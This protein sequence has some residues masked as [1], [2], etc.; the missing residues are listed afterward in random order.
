MFLYR[1]S[2]FSSS[3]ALAIRPWMRL[4]ILPSIWQQKMATCQSSNFSQNENIYWTS[5]ITWGKL[6]FTWLQALV[7]CLL[8]NCFLK[9]DPISRQRTIEK[10]RRFIRQL[11]TAKPRLW[12]ICSRKT[13]CT[14][15]LI[16]A[17]CCHSIRYLFWRNYKLQFHVWCKSCQFNSSNKRALF[18]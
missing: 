4:E 13:P 6:L 18:K 1:L 16:P 10:K 7:I 12:N 11:K 15:W 14:R 9:L 8:W 5:R 17:I 3:T 2:N